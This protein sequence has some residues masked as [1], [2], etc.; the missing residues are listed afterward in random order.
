MGKDVVDRACPGFDAERPLVQ[1][2]AAAAGVA[3]INGLKVTSHSL[4]AGPNT[5]MA[6]AL[7]P[8]SERNTA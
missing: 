2:R 5:N 6:E 8:L 4:R 3:L 7:I 1:A